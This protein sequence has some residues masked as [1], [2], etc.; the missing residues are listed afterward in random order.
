VR[1]GVFA[2]AALV[3]AVLASTA[4]AVAF[5]GDYTGKTSQKF[6]F[7]MKLGHQK[8]TGKSY[9]T[10]TVNTRIRYK[11]PS[12]SLTQAY[13]LS[14]PISVHP[15]GRFSEFIGGGPTDFVSHFSGAF[16]GNKVSGTIRGASFIDS[17]GMCTSANVQFTA[18]R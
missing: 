9:V 4:L 8:I 11:C 10:A 12:G 14:G 5:H 17:G 6:A 18:E 1:G 16:K 7:S 3:S 2:V 13:G 15:N